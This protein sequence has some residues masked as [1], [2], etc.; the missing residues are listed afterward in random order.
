MAKKAKAKKKTKKNEKGSA[1]KEKE[2]RKGGGE[3]ED[4]EE[5]GTKKG[6][7]KPQEGSAAQGAGEKGAG[8]G[9]AADGGA[10]DAVLAL[11]GLRRWRRRQLLAALRSRVSRIGNRIKQVG[12]CRLAVAASSQAGLPRHREPNSI[13]VL[14]AGRGPESFV[15]GFQ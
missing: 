2:S 12:Q 1:G 5:G 6:G 7:K 10:L 9:S 15:G 8:P 13:A 11:H 3:E 4:G 14:E